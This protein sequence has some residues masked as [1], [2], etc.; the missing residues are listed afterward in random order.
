MAEPAFLTRSPEAVT[1]TGILGYPRLLSGQRAEYSRREAVGLQ[2]LSISPSIRIPAQAERR[3]SVVYSRT[4]LPGEV[5][6]TPLPCAGVRLLRIP[7]QEGTALLYTDE[8]G[9]SLLF[10]FDGDFAPLCAFCSSFVKGFK[11][12][13]PYAKSGGETPFP[14]VVDWE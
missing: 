1:G 14:A 7:T 13:L 10:S 8:S 2:G 4:A 9:Y 12:F 11:G 6:W 3:I 5:D